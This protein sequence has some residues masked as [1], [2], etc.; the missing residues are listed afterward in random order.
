MTI[1]LSQDH[2]A[3]AQ[4]FAELLSS[5]RCPVLTRDEARAYT[6][7]VSDSAFDRWCAR[8]RVT[9]SSRGRYARQ[10]L[11]L[12]LEREGCLRPTPSSLRNWVKK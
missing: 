9:S 1:I 3:L 8:W 2:E 7:S 10:N 12:A 5:V 11:D 4:R 6:K